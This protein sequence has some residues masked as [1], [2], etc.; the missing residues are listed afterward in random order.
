MGIFGMRD[1]PEV[2]NWAVIGRKMQR[3]LVCWL[4]HCSL[5][6]KSAMI[7]RSGMSAYGSIA[8]FDMHLS[9]F[10]LLLPFT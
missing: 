10:Q 7:R 3:W 2:A 6:A 5:V 9:I 8:L 4:M 1:A